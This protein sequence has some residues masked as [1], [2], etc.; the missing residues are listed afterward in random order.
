MGS[1]LLRRWV[2]QP[3]LDIA[4]L[5][6]RQQLISELLSDTLI[7]AKLA[8]ALKKTGD[9]ERLINRVRQRIATPR[10]LVTLATDYQWGAVSVGGDFR[11]TSRFERVELYPN[12]DRVAGK[13]LDLRAGVERG[14]LSLRCQLTNALNYIYNQVPRT[15]APVRTLSVTLTWTY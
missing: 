8:E 2:G 7:Q 1:R 14:P 6:Q 11:Y 12:D 15:L 13:V 4:I 3:L 5:E 10:D 9:I